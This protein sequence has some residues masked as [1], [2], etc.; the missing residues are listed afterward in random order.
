MLGLFGFNYLMNSKYGFSIQ[1]CVYDVKCGKSVRV[2]ERSR[3]GGKRRAPDTV[4][5]DLHKDSFK[6][7]NNVTNKKII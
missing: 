6:N 5:G 3:Y 1:F 2:C 4:Y 7:A